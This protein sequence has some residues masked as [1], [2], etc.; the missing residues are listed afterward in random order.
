[1]TRPLELDDTASPGAP[2]VSLGE[3][4]AIGRIERALFGGDERL[5]R[6]GRCEV[7]E[8]IG[9]GAF[10]KVYRARDPQLGRTIALKVLAIE[11]ARGDDLLG[12]ARVM[13]TIGHP[14][15]AAVHDA[16]VLAD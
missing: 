4:A 9:A 6:G 8:M 3:A 7:I 11:N 15:V 2:T 16:G 5:V 13:A 10:G 12:E 1:M 14:N